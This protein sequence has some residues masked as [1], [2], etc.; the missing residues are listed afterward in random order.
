MKK[1]IMKKVKIFIH[2]FKNYKK[3]YCEKYIIKK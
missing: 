1:Y 3:I 2:K